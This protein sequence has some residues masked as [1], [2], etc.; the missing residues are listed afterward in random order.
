M[1][2]EAQGV[3]GDSGRISPHGPG[4]NGLGRWLAVGLGAILVFGPIAVLVVVYH[5][6]GSAAW[7]AALSLTASP[8]LQVLAEARWPVDPAIVRSR[9]QLGVEI[10]QGI[11]Y[12]GLL[13]VGVVFALWRGIIALRDA[14]GVEVSLAGG[15]WLQALALVVIADFFDY[16]RHRHEHESSGLFWRIHSVHHSIR[17]FSLLSGLALHP[18]ETVLTYA[19][20]GL[21]AGALGLPLDAL[22]L[23]FALALIVMGAQHTNVASSLGRLSSVLAHTDGHRW[24]HDIALEAGHNVNYANVFS[25][26]DRLWGSYY[27]PRDFDGE[28]GITPFRDAYPKGLLEQLFIV[29]PGRYARAEASARA[30]SPARSGPDGTEPRPDDANRS[31]GVTPSTL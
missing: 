28:Y 8:L 27:A 23:G 5:S 16:F 2:V 26:W 20:Y 1:E 31:A 12:G 3:P 14:L 30:P 15:V 4:R 21:V 13:G 17:R 18:L 25:F 9:R 11:F 22:L 24:H 19:S 6:T 10:F 7:A 29:L